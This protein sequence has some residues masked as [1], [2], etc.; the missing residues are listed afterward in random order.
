ME[1]WDGLLQLRERVLAQI[2]PLRQGKQI[3]SSLQAKVVLSAPPDQ[4]ARLTAHQTDLPM[5]FIVSNVE[6]RPLA[7]EVPAD[8]VM[9]RIAIER[10]HGVKCERCWRYVSSVSADPAW[11]GL[12]DRCQT[13]L[14]TNDAGRGGPGGA[15]SPGGTA[16]PSRSSGSPDPSGPGAGASG[17]SGRAGASGRGRGQEPAHP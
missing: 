4:L 8:E 6:L 12:C 10:T 7:G 11:A 17:P 9:P 2:E 14:T 13:A 15:S 16:G 5:L 3:G 1:R